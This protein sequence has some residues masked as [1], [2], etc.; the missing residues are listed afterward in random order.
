ALEA[1]C[2]CAGAD[3]VE[4]DGE[5]ARPTDFQDILVP[6]DLSDEWSKREKYRPAAD[7]A[8]AKGA[9]RLSE[10]RYFLA[11]SA[12]LRRQQVDMHAPTHLIGRRVWPYQN[13]A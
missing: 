10:L 4:V 3:L 5:P 2:L 6:G 11:K 8:E 9:E 13:L 7:R 1:V 12:F